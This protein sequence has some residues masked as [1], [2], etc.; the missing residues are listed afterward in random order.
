[1]LSVEPQTNRNGTNE[2]ITPAT[3]ANVSQ[4]DDAPD[5]PMTLEDR[6]RIL[7]DDLRETKKDLDDFKNNDPVFPK[8]LKNPAE[9][10]SHVPRWNKSDFTKKKLKVN[11]VNFTLW[12]KWAQKGNTNKEYF[13][14]PL[15]P[16]Q[17]HEKRLTFAAFGSVILQSFFTYVI[18]QYAIDNCNPCE[19]LC[20]ASILEDK[21]N[22]CKETFNSTGMIIAKAVASIYLSFVTSKEL[23]SSWYCCR[24]WEF[25]LSSDR[26]TVSLKT[27]LLHFILFATQWIQMAFLAGVANLVVFSKTSMIGVFTVASALNLIMNIDDV[28]GEYFCASICSQPNSLR[29]QI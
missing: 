25:E 3:S 21:C 8:N 26:V 14:D 11:I 29:I 1:M 7:E 22:I 19:D 5:P 15:V 28:I 17:H 9:C 12:Y 13:P 4:R 6:I 20:A 18:Q 10:D 24:I 2:N 23:N 27:R 16:D